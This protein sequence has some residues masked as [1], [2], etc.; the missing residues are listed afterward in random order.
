[1]NLSDM[2]EAGR[3]AEGTDPKSVKP[4]PLVVDLDGTLLRTDTLIESVLVLARKHPLDLLR[5]PLWLAGGRARFKRRLA[6]RVALDVNTLPRRPDLLDHLADQKRRGRQLILASGADER[7]ARAV[8]DDAGIF[9]VVLASDGTVNLTDAAKRERLVRDF[10]NRGFDY[11]GNSQRDLPIWAVARRGILVG[12][13]ARLAADARRVTRVERQF[14]D[15]RVALSTYLEAMRPHHWVKNLLLFVPLAA[16]HR[17]DDPGAL[18]PAALGMLC[19]CLAAAGIYL[20]NDLLDL[21]ADRRHPRKRMRALAAGKIPLLHAILLALGL[22]TAAALLSLALPPSFTLALALYVATMVVYSLRLKDIGVVDA[23]VLGS[24]Y[25]L[26]VLAGGLAA[27]IVVSPWLLAGIG[28][29]FLGLALLKRYA[30][31]IA[32]GAS[33]PHTCR[34]SDAAHTAQRGIGSCFAGM[35]ILAAFPLLDSS[36]PARWPV[37]LLCACLLLWTGRMWVMAG[38]GRITDDPVAFAMRDRPSRALAVV[39][40]AILAI[41]S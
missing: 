13:S 11:A 17:L 31:M 15:D 19:F 29:L 10:G 37:W 34:S 21:P 25:A 1:M 33:L 8:A 24:G 28:L 12:A 3:I 2:C 9:D 38:R 20:L 14:P 27:G 22:W 6:A 35:L 30:N 40:A 36:G 4:V 7:V 16:S 41:A 18:V 5:L 23:F 32:H 39:A 26:R